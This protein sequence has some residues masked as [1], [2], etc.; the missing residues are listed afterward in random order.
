[1]NI[2]IKIFAILKKIPLPDKERKK[3]TEEGGKKVGLGADT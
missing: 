2:H 3:L 1:L